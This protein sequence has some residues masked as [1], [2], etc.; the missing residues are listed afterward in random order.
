MASKKTEVEAIE[1]GLKALYEAVYFLLDLRGE[2]RR[3]SELKA[4]FDPAPTDETTEDAG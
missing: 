4:Y 3:M 1:P 2:K